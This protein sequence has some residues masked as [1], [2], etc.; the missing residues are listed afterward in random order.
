[1]KVRLRGLDEQ[2]EQ[3]Q[4]RGVATTK[5]DRYGQVSPLSVLAD[6]VRQS[7]SRKDLRGLTQA[8]DETRG[9]IAD[10]KNARALYELNRQ[11]EQDSQIQANWTDDY[12]LKLAR[13]SQSEAREV[14]RQEELAAELALESQVG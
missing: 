12:A 5:Q 10:N 4:A 14:S 1:M 2:Y 7:K 6:V 8:R 11:Q 9:R 13:Q 3:A